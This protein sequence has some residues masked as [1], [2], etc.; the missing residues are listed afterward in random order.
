V[1]SDAR[2]DA[3]RDD[4]ARRAHRESPV[5]RARD[6][7]PA[8]HVRTGKPRDRDRTPLVTRTIRQAAESGRRSPA[9]SATREAAG[10]RKAQAQ[11]KAPAQARPGKAEIALPVVR[12]TGIVPEPVITTVDRV[13]AVQR[14]VTAVLQLGAAVPAEVLEVRPGRI[15][16][17][18]PS[19]AGILTRTADAVN[20]LL[21]PLTPVVATVDRVT[22]VVVPEAPHYPALPGGAAGLP[23]TGSPE[24]VVHPRPIASAGAPP[25]PA[26][27]HAPALL[28]AVPQALVPAEPPAWARPWLPCGKQPA[29][30]PDRPASQAVPAAAGEPGNNHRP[31]PWPAPGT[32]R[33][34]ML[35]TVA[36]PG[37]DSGAGTWAT[38]ST[39]WRPV[40]CRAGTL[41]AVSEGRYGRRP[42]SAQPP[43]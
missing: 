40:L 36:T 14:P 13:V 41:H 15:A 6:D 9:G 34:G 18:L 8:R 27:A 5:E 16:V 17:V 43:G 30:L 25:P 29:G 32:P 39:A 26:A 2:R 20:P 33:L 42:T 12:L 24:V 28:T 11:G 4:G 37:A 31:G 3:R 21:A 35:S 7:G 1:R 10:H 23:P 19:P 38:T 22:G